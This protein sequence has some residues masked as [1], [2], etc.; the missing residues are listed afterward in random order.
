MVLGLLNRPEM[1]ES[2]AHFDTFPC[3]FLVL[4][5]QFVEGEPQLVVVAGLFVQVLDL[6]SEGEDLLIFLLKKVFVVF[7]GFEG[8]FFVEEKC[9]LEFIMLLFEC[10][11]LE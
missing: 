4:F 1:G 6:L 7:F 5:L 3:E 9:V 2:F 10:G 8:L 11:M